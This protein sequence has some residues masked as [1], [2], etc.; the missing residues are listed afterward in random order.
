MSTSKLRRRSSPT[1][2]QTEEKNYTVGREL[3]HNATEQSSSSKATRVYITATSL[4]L[5]AVLF[6]YLRFSSSDRF[7]VSYILCSPPG[8]ISIYTIDDRNAKVECLAV[9]E[10]QIVDTGALGTSVRTSQPST[11]YISV[12]S[13]SIQST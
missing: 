13:Q 8:A 9:N 10:H 6:L 7:P 2:A 1:S 12:I 11:L 4:A 3:N 5:S